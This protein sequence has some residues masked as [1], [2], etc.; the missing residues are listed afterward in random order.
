MKLQLQYFFCIAGQKVL[1]ALYRII[2]AITTYCD[3]IITWLEAR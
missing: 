1:E 2:H 3:K